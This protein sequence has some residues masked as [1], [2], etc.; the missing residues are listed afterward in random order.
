[1][2]KRLIIMAAALILLNVFT[3]V[4][5]AEEDE[6][7]VPMGEITLKALATKPERAVVEFPHTKHFN[8]SCTECHHKWI[9]EESIQGCTASGCHDSAQ[10]PKDANGTPSTDALLQI[11]YYKNAYHT[12]CLGCHKEIKR[13]NKELEASQISNDAKLAAVGPTG[14]IQ[15]HPKD[16]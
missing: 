10:A 8:Y 1:M 12:M 6:M 7:C 11:K 4:I 15:C 5:W 9:K 3:G 2:R 16:D 14:C 13:K